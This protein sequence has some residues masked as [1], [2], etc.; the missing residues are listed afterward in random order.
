MGISALSSILCVA[1][2]IFQ[3]DLVGLTI[4]DL[5]NRKKKKKALLIEGHGSVN[6]LI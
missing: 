2:G 3:K 4:K 6:L 1:L 5:F